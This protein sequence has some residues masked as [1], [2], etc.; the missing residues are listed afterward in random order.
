[1]MQLEVLHVTER[2]GPDK[3]TAATVGQKFNHHNQLAKNHHVQENFIQR[4]DDSHN[5]FNAVMHFE[6]LCAK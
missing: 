2:R 6:F 1:M 5:F 4:Q 3:F